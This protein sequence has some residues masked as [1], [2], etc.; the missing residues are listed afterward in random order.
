MG[1]CSA[2]V[3]DEEPVVAE[4]TEKSSPEDGDRKGGGEE[5]E[6]SNTDFR[7]TLKGVIILILNRLVTALEYEQ[8]GFLDLA[9]KRT[10]K[11]LHGA[12]RA[13]TFRKVTT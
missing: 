13:P 4:Q 2:K 10:K 7:E 6:A 3:E 8:E 9:T 11:K 12:Y 5:K 1:I